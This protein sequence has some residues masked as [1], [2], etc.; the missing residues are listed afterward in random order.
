MLRKL[1]REEIEKYASRKGVRRIAV[2]NSLMTN[3]NN[4]D[5]SVALANLN[6]NTRL[7]H[8]SAETY[9]AIRVGILASGA[10]K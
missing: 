6:M 10:E 3:D 4:P 8:W 7:Y 9:D 2:E 1:S 5:I